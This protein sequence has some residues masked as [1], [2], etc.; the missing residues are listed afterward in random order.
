MRLKVKI[1][2]HAVDVPISIPALHL[3]CACYVGMCY[4]LKVLK[5]EASIDSCRTIQA[6]LDPLELGVLEAKA[7]LLARDVKRCESA[8]CSNCVLRLGSSCASEPDGDKS[9]PSRPD[10]PT[11]SERPDV[12]RMPKESGPSAH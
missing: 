2:S 8:L 5:L 4:R 1:D 6:T 9:H 7:N 3:N 11:C 10:L 12:R